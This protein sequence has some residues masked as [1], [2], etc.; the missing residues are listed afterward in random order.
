MAVFGGDA[1]GK[2]LRKSM[3]IKEQIFA[4]SMTFIIPI[5]TRF[6]KRMP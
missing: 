1:G 5:K 3:S 4:R 2:L 6:I